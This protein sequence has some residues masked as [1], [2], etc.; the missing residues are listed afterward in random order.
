MYPAW[1]QCHPPD[2]DSA[3]SCLG[4]PGLSLLPPARLV[5]RTWD[6]C[7]NSFPELLLLL[8]LTRCYVKGWVRLAIARLIPLGHPPDL[9]AGPGGC[10]SGCHHLPGTCN[11]RSPGAGRELEHICPGDA[12]HLSRYCSPPGPWQA[13]GRLGWAE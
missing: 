9:P 2:P 7:D 1:L 8:A 6:M 13:A 4:I 5:T 3:G 11:S 12:A 10:R